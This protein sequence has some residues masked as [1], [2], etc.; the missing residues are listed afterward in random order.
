MDVEYKKI[1]VKQ[2]FGNQYSYFKGMLDPSFPGQL[3]EEIAVYLFCNADHS[4][5]KVTGRS[6]TE[7]FGV[8][9][10]M[11]VLCSPKQQTRVQTLTLGAEFTALKKGVEEA[12]TL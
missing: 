7:L 9:G 1:E 10:S 8:V 5:N 3:F 2:D 6:I 11:P 4:H 12:V